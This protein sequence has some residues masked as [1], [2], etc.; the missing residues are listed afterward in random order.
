MKIF[1]NISRV[2]GYLIASVAVVLA[3]V[4]LASAA[5]VLYKRYTD[6]KGRFAF[7]YPS[8]MEVRRPG[9]DEV[10]IY[11]PKASLRISVFLEN[12]PTKK[13]AD[14]RPFLDALE[15]QLKRDKQDVKILEQ[16]H[17]PGPKDRQGY[18]ICYFVE[19]GGAKRVQ[20]VQYFVSETRV[21]QMVIFDHPEGFKNLH[22]VIRHIHR[23][24]E[25]IKPTLE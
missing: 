10:K 9:P 3:L 14:V 23:S 6:S 7:E 21:L 5:E 13:P 15:T 22:P 12:R 8:T 20:L 16:G 11:H 24:L 18:L 1:P 17:L 19:S 2:W 4:A 25:I